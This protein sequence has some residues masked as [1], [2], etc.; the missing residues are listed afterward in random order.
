MTTV[1]I[2]HLERWV[3]HNG[4]E[5]LYFRNR[6]GGGKRVPLRGPLGSPEF[7]EDYTAAAE[8]PTRATG[9]GSMRWL[10][11]QYCMSAAHRQLNPRTQTV[12]RGILDRF[13]REHGD[14][15]FKQLQPKHLR[16]IRDTMVDRPG[17]ANGLLKALRQVFKYAVEYDLA[18]ANPVTQVGYLKPKDKGGFHAWTLDE[19]EAF[20]TAHPIGS[21]A[22]LAMALLLYTCQRRGDIVRLG[23]QHAREGWLTF[24]QQKGGKPMDIPI[25]AELQRIIDASPTGDLAYLVTAFGKPFTAAG[26]GNRF[27]KWC[28]TAKLPQC[29]AHGL[30]KAAAARMAELG[31]TS[32]EIMAI[33]GW[34]TLKEVERYTRGAERKRLA[35]RAR[36]RIENK[37]SQLSRGFVPTIGNRKEKQ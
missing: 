23:R 30:R 35:G 3:D 17:A 31:C 11:Q 7:W 27:R 18:D 28:D 14:K 21:K 10:I 1:G 9:T 16:R 32:H 37:T 26:F 20:E 12:R 25:L 19:V 34:D 24:T 2:K 8:Q 4:H 22:R 36:D 29:S 33:G 6:R 5:R 15:S 13:C